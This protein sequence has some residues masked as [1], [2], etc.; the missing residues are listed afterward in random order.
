MDYRITTLNE[1]VKCEEQLIPAFAEAKFGNVSE[2]TMVF[3]STAFYIERGI[4]EIDYRTFQRVNK[5]YIE[6]FINNGAFTT[7]E[8][9]FRNK[10]GHTLINKDLIFL[11]IIFADPTVISYFNMI[12]GDALTNGVAYSDG[13]IMS[14]ASQRIPSEV[15]QQIINSRNDGTQDE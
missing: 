15:L 8:I 6:G 11:F 10:D 14:L 1:Q 4:D 5:R 3:D 12:V 13:F 7:S 9:F 2:R